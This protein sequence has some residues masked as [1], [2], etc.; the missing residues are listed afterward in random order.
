L[1][2]IVNVLENVTDYNLFDV[3]ADNE[4]RITP[5]NQ[6]VA[7]MPLTAAK[8][9]PVAIRPL[10]SEESSQENIN[11]L[12]RTVSDLMPVSFIVDQDG[13]IPHSSN[14][15]YN[16]DR[17]PKSRDTWQGTVIIPHFPYERLLET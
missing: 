2:D 14:K 9:V 7:I 13:Y 15:A 8:L 5:L 1:S 10:W 3:I 12:R 16:I 17:D 11:G 6:L 4:R